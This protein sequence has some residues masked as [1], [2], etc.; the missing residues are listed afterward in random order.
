MTSQQ[1]VDCLAIGNVLPS[2]LVIIV[3]FVGFMGRRWIGAVLCTIGMFLPAF[4]FTM[5]HTAMEWAVKHDLLSDFLDG[6]TVSV[7]GMIG[8]VSL[9]LLTGTAT[10]P[11]HPLITPMIP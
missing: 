1:F 11:R 3:T 6:V 10:V 4:S 5:F 8:I 7:V 2:P 9:E